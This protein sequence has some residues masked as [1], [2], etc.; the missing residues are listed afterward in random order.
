M[1]LAL[2]HVIFLHTGNIPSVNFQVYTEAEDLQRFAI[3]VEMFRTLKDYRKAAILENRRSGIP[4]QRP[5]LLHHEN[6]PVVYDLQYEY[7]LG[8]DLLVAPVTAPDV[9]E[10][11]VYLPK[12]TWVYL[13]DESEIEGPQETVVPAPLGR[14]P[15]F[16]RKDS[17]WVETFRR[18]GNIAVNGLKDE[19]NQIEGQ[20]CDKDTCE[21]L[22]P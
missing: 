5:L 1:L 21:H 3:L 2:M 15:V 4:L 20:Q 14:I 10:W 22:A 17:Q 18:L 13:Y 6:D 7:L 16:Y 19:T 11:K 12:D 8:R 9:A